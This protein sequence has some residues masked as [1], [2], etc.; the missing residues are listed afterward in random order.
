MPQNASN[1]TDITCD[2]IKQIEHLL[3]EL[4]GKQG[5]VY[6][7]TKIKFRLFNVSLIGSMHSPGMYDL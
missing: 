7:N 2:L 4:T 6:F 1:N 5:L 3:I